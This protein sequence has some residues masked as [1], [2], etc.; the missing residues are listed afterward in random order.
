[1]RVIAGLASANSNYI[2]Q[3]NKKRVVWT[4]I[5]QEDIPPPRS[6]C[7]KTRLGSLFCEGAISDF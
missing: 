5:L 2:L 1:M 3:V 6:Q 4:H 7:H